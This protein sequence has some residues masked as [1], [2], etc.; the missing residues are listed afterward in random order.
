MTPLDATTH[1]GRFVLVFNNVLEFAEC[2]NLVARLASARW[3]RHNYAS[4]MEQTR[5]SYDDDLYVTK[6][7]PLSVMKR[8]NEIDE[9]AFAE[10]IARV[11]VSGWSG[12]GVC[13][14]ARINKYPTGT[15]MRKHCDH[16][17][18]LFDPS[19]TY[20]G[21][22]G[23]PVLSAV[24]SL[25]DDYEGGQFVMWENQIIPLSK[26][27]VLV[28]PSSFMFPHQVFPITNGER[29]SWVSWAW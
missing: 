20:R 13:S 1:V 21:A 24:G 26:G 15:K 22:R 11:G 12:V 27:S 10:Y 17:T 25:N 6:D 28:F 16:I 3:E 19:N 8:L 4:P 7:I 5:I 14:N 18:T 23:V 9:I 29:I 2:D